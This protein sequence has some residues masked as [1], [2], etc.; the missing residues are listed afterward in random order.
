VVD[1][2]EYCHPDW[3]TSQ[4]IVILS[5]AKD[6]LLPQQSHACLASLFKL[7]HY[8]QEAMSVSHRDPG[9]STCRKAFPQKKPSPQ[10]NARKIVANK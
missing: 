1:I 8:R 3:L 2:T 4:S 9:N 5:E 10:K 7:R 6:L